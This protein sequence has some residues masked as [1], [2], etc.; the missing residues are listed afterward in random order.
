M[1]DNSNAMALHVESKNAKDTGLVKIFL[2][3]FFLA[4]LAAGF[5]LVIILL[6]GREFSWEIFYS[7]F[8]IFI[9]I[10]VVLPLILGIAAAS[11]YKRVEI[12]LTPASSVN[13]A[14]LKEFFLKSSYLPA[15]EENSKFTFKR[16]KTFRRALCLNSDMPTIQVNGQ[17]V[18]IIMLKRKSLSLVNQLSSDR[19]YEVG[20]EK[21][22]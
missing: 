14:K 21:V 15:A 4:L 9:P 22:E 17:A 20:S 16:S 7:Y 6:A 12:I 2:L 3:H 8:I 5:L 10:T 1:F 11:S 19:R 18:S 13:L